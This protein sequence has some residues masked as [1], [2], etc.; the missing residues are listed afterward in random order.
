MN[1]DAKSG[2]QVIDEFFSEITN[3]EGVDLKTVN[4]LK[5]LHSE[6]KLT[7]TNIENELSQLIQEE[8]SAIEGE[9]GKN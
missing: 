7:E 1:N 9:N 5:F 2:G 6:G 3:L 4:M 8:L